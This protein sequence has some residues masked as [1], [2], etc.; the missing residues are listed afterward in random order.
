MLFS[1]EDRTVHEALLSR[2]RVR[3]EQLYRLG[4]ALAAWAKEDKVPSLQALALSAE[5]GART[6]GALLALL[7]EATLVRWDQS[8]VYVTV[9]ADEIEQ[10][11]RELA[12]QFET[13]RT[14]DARRLDAVAEYAYTQ[15][16]R[17]VFL[18]EY[19][20]ESGGERCGLCDRCR[21]QEDRPQSFWQPLAP[22]RGEERP[23]RGRRGRRPR[24]GARDG[25][26]RRRR[27]SRHPHRNG[28]GPRPALAGPAPEGSEAAGARPGRSG[29]R[30]RGR[31]G[32]RRGRRPEGGPDAP[33]PPAPPEP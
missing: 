15:G 7:E 14:Q 11:S 28:G 16:C 2:S 6:T 3:P 21:G 30:R 29:R 12:G 17:A 9:P 18:R 19:F 20:G 25:R 33:R 32:R 31:R 8:A 27:G 1:H 5:L 4:A 10:R 26:G 13:L 23:G 24:P 22:P